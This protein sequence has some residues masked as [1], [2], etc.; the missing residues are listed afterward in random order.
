MAHDVS[1]VRKPVHELSLSDRA[2]TASFDDFSTYPLKVLDGVVARRQLVHRVLER[3]RS[4][5]TQSPPDLHAQVGG[6]RREL[7]NEEGPARPA[8]A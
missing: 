3:H 1:V 7:M 6:L 8:A 2:F 5:S 4:H